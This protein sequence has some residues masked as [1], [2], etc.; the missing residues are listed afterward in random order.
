MRIESH[1]SNARCSNAKV[2]PEAFVQEPGLAHNGVFAQ[3]ASDV[4][5]GDMAGHHT[6]PQSICGEYHQD[7]ANTC[8]VGEVFGVPWK[9]ELP[10]LDGVFVD[11]RSH[12]DI[13]FI[14]SQV[15]NRCLQAEPSEFTCIRMGL[16]PIR[17]GQSGGDVHTVQSA[18]LGPLGFFCRLYVDLNIKLLCLCTQSFRVTVDHRNH[19]LEYTLIGKSLEDTFRADTMG[20]TPGNADADGFGRCHGC[21]GTPEGEGAGPHR[22]DLCSGFFCTG[23]QLLLCLSVYLSVSMRSFFFLLILCL[24][25]PLRMEATHNRAGEI[26]Y[27]HLT[28]STYEVTITTYT[29]ASVVADREFLQIQWGDEGSEGITDS[30]PRINGPVNPAGIP[31]GELLAG[32]IRLNL[33]RG[34]HTYAG[35]GVYSLIVEDPNRNAGVLNIPGSVDVPFCISSLLIIDPQAGH[36]DSPTLLYPAIEN[37]CINQVWEH[38]PG[39]YDPD[40]DSL[41]YDLVSCA[42][43]NCSPIQNFVQPNQVE[44]AGGEFY[45]EPTTGTVVWDAPGLAGEYNIALRI[46]EWREVAGQWILVGE[47]TRDMQITVEICNNEPPVVEVLPD[48]CV[49]QGSSLI[50]Q[51]GASDPNG[52]DVTVTVVGGP[53]DALD[54]EAVFTWNP[55]MDAGTFSWVPGCDAVREAPY[56]LVFKATDDDAIPL[57]DVSTMRVKVI[58]RPVSTT[59]AVPIGNAV[60]VDWSVHPCAGSYSEALQA[61]GGYEIYRRNGPGFPDLG[62]CT[63]GMPANAGY[64]QVGFVNGLG[65]NAF[66]DTESISFGAR[67]CYR[68]VAVMPNGARSR[69]G[70]E[71]CAE[72]NKEVPVMTGAS[73]EVS[74]L[75]DGEVEV[76][77]S[78]P[79]DADTLEAFPGPYRY[80]VEARSV[81]GEGWQAI[82][83]TATSVTLGNLDTVTVHTGIN[84]EVP[85]WEY[86]VLAWSGEDLIGKSSPAPVPELQAN[87]GDNRVNLSVPPGRP[88]S[89]TAYVFHR[90]LEDGSLQLLD[91]A[92]VPFLADTGLVNG[93]LSCYRVRTLGTYGAEGILDPI[94]NW[95]AVRCAIP[96][97]FEPPCPPELSVTPDCPAEEITLSWSPLTCA[98]DVMAYRVYRSDSL[99]GPLKLVLELDDIGDTSITLSAEEW[100]NSIAGC[101]AVSALD[102][103]MPGP[104]GG[105]RRNESALSDTLCTDNCPFYFLP[106][107]FTPNLDGTNDR[108]RPFPWKFVDSVDFR[109]FN[110]WGEE[111]WRSMDPDLGWDGL[112]QSTGAMCADGTYHYTCTAYTR[113]LSGTV[114]ERFSGT[115]QMLGG[116]APPGE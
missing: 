96:Y 65:S 26:T 47:V 10:P 79:S 5:D 23:G 70:P 108:F 116:V 69:F 103:L 112:H 86:M 71:A 87:G 50:F 107:V 67:Y 41:T 76:R 85:I 91:T 7:I 1:D 72:I 53:T 104:N 19:V 49:L 45:V 88:W 83:E 102:S 37:A 66:L 58:A 95:S 74:D 110:R 113:R 30:L 101:W 64:T 4:F 77:W 60:E 55:I 9:F 109:V 21:E 61:V 32:D 29:K 56:Q 89:D 93:E 46:R 8:H 15:L 111:V 36:N 114:P 90:V 52:D 31:T 39:A 3:R 84:S 59:D 33:Y 94:E 73:V 81:A 17:L 99:S 6:D 16:S 35:P 54:P 20:V 40:G 11:G 51:V 24:S 22:F 115:F 105:L 13:D 63:V 80:E 43:F 78:A 75:V 28:G 14:G 68:V 82:G 57:S 97:D 92:A 2:T 25:I 12:Q 106:N 34:T 100:G 42:G 48:T 62:Y 44:G 98:D 27:R 38:N 18:L